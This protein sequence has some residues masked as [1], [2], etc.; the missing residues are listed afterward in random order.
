MS[1]LLSEV[2]LD[3]GVLLQVHGRDIYLTDNCYFG[4]PL[5]YHPNWSQHTPG[6]TDAQT[7]GQLLR[8]TGLSP[9]LLEQQAAVL[10]RHLAELH[11]PESPDYASDTTHRLI[12]A[13][14][15]RLQ[16][17][18]AALRHKLV[19]L[20]QQ[21]V[22]LDE[23]QVKALFA[24]PHY[25]AE[26]RGDYGWHGQGLRRFQR[27]LVSP[28]T[29]LAV[30]D[31]HIAMLVKALAAV[32]CYSWCSC[33]G[34]ADSESRDGRAPLR[35][36]LIDKIN[37]DW[38]QHLIDIAGQQ[39]AILDLEVRGTLLIETEHS[40]NS[41]DR[42]LGKVRTQAIQLGRFIYRSRL[43]LRAERKAWTA[44]YAAHTSLWSNPSTV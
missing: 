32:G 12:K 9:E 19:R 36:D 18:P 27:R 44:Q 33:Q 1:T 26:A 41:A 3:R 23:R 40:L 42:A 31:P 5:G 15:N 17:L 30:L 25:R 24:Q 8:T 22:N 4:P 14:S 38:A 16:A 2:L 13:L 43:L 37:A 35:I 21:N 28:K 20:Q 34:Y 7:L 29:P 11:D 10:H 39:L 6:L